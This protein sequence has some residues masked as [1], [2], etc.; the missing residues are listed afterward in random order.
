VRFVL[1]DLRSERTPA[2]APD[3]PDKTML[4]AAQKAW[5]KRE[6]LAARDAGQLAVWVSTV[7]W[8]DGAKAFAP[9]RSVPRGDGWGAYA[10]ERRELATFLAERRIEDLVMLSGDAHMLAIDDGRHGG[11]GPPG[12]RGF[13]VMHAAALDRR[14]SRK[15]GPYSEGAL[16]NPPPRGRLQ[17]GQFG[18]MAVRDAGGRELC[19]EWRGHRV[20][21]ATGATTVLLRWGRCFD[22][23]STTAAPERRGS[24]PG[25]P[26]P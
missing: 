25:P 9:L 6:L 2:A 22:L 8:I 10:H 11:Y 19:L 23:T 7:P 12:S 14:G 5:W 17:A 26:A 13:P 20:E 21:P 18:T 15:G 24:R 1:T 16:P 3:G 4:G